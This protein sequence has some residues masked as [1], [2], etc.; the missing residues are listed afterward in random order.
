[1]SEEKIYVGSGKEITFKDGGSIIKIN[2]SP[3]DL[4]KL[5]N[6]KSK[7]GWVNLELH[8]RKAPSEK[9][10][11]HYLCVDTWKPEATNTKSNSA[12]VNESDDI[13]F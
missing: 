11:T 13:P 2:I 1:M 9:G 8:K 3:D 4:V 10:Q 6:A 7:G 12:P 5:N